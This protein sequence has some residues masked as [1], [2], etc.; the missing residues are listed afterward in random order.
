MGMIEFFPLRASDG[1]LWRAAKSGSRRQSVSEGALA[2][3]FVDR[4]CREVKFLDGWIGWNGE[5]WTG[6]EITV[7]S[8]VRAI[9]REAAEEHD[10]PRIDSSRG[11]NAILALVKYDPRIFVGRRPFHPDLEAAV[12]GWISDY[13]E[14]DAAA[15]TMRSAMLPTTK[16]LERFEIEELNEAL[17]AR[18][19][20]YRRRGHTHGYAG[21]KLRDGFDLSAIADKPTASARS[22]FAALGLTPEGLRRD[23]DLKRWLAAARRAYRE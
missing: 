7:R 10:D 5:K 15:W 9:C 21:F 1:N 4:H 2:D 3:L 23:S 6:N 13:C 22:K 19:I 8:I 14:L 11:V 12:D 16:V 20:T 17:A 18:G